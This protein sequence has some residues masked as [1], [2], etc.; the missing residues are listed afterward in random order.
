M[1][2]KRCNE[3]GVVCWHN[4]LKATKDG[5]SGSRCTHC[6]APLGTGPKKDRMVAINARQIAKARAAQGRLI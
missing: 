5:N 4:P 3:C 2:K 1:I 6:G